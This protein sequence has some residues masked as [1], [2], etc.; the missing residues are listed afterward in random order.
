[1]A[2]THRRQRDAGKQCRVRPALPRKA[3]ACPAVEGGQQPSDTN[4]RKRKIREDV[5]RVWHPDQRSLIGELVIGRILGD[6]RR[7]KQR[8]KDGKER[9]REGEVANHAFGQR[10]LTA[11][12]CLAV[13]QSLINPSTERGTERTENYPVAAGNSSRINMTKAT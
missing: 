10:D 8:D 7:E 6:G 2:R 9:A 4:K 11:P 5:E 3:K 13:R 1:M 12:G